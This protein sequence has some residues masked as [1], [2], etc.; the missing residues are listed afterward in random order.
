[1]SEKNFCTL[2]TT[3][4]RVRGLVSGGTRQFKGVPYGA[5]TAG[6][7]R[8]QGPKRPAPWTG[9][10]D[11]IGYAPVSPQ[12]PTD[13]A[14]DYGRLVQF[15]LNGAF[16]GIGEDCL[17]L[18]IWTP[19]TDPDGKRAVLFSIH[20]G[21][22]ALGSG[23]NPMYDGARLAAFGDVVVVTVTHRLAAFGFLGLAELDRGGEWADAG[24]AG[25]LDL[26]AALEWVRDN[27][28]T[29]GGDPDRV[30]IFG[31]SG[32]GWKVSALLAMPAAR[33]LFHRAA[34]QSGSLL[35]HVSRDDGARIALAFVDRL[36]LSKKRLG[37]LR[38]LPWTEL[39]DAQTAV[40]A[41][42]FAPVIDDVHLRADPFHPA[43]PG[44]SV[45]VPLIVS[46]TLDDAGLFF[47]TFSLGEAE[48]RQLLLAGYGD[49]AADLLALYR[50]HFPA[51]SPY[52]LYSQIITDAG[53]R[54]LA[55]IQAEL[56]A[57]QR[58]APV[59]SYLWEWTSPA[60]DAKFGAVHAMDV[61]ASFHNDRDPILGGGGQQALAMCAALAGAWVNF[62]KTGEPGHALLPPWPR[63]D[64]GRRATLVFGER[65][66]VVPDPYAEIRAFWLDLPGP[67]GVFG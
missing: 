61:A 14:N 60:F 58:G 11:C 1:M 67:T 15:D 36:G 25:L 4:G 22:F 23:N 41:H 12:M 35:R 46:T 20:G 62:A 30:T 18:N 56:K 59:F 45:D 26:V 28:A 63:F 10:R 9:V 50:A 38:T 66:R 31:Q 7:N 37:E 29:F 44:E 5:S 65:T 48:L 32:G 53:F 52:L 24:A 40:G 47:N 49:R 33:G 8:F 55:N 13:V 57:A 17:H 3:N 21:G 16:G 39:L 42:L 19:G 51:K 43:A 27:I 2:E 6:T 64:A 34:V 54:R